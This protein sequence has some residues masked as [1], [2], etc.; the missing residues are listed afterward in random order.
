MGNKAHNKSWIASG[1]LPRNDKKFPSK[2]DN[3]IH[4]QGVA[5]RSSY[6]FFKPKQKERTRQNLVLSLN[7]ARR[8]CLDLF[9]LNVSTCFATEFLTLCKSTPHSAHRPLELQ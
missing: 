8:D 1:F 9:A 2:T 4:V 7:W 5:L 6:L 3:K